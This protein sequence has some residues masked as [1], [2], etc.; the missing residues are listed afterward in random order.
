MKSVLS[1]H[2]GGKAD[3]YVDDGDKIKFGHEH[4]EVAE[5]KRFNPR[6]TKSEDEFVELMSKLNL[7]YPKQIGCVTYVSQAHKMAFTGDALLIRGCGRTDFQQG[8][9]NYHCITAMLFSVFA[10]SLNSRVFQEMLTRCIGHNYDGLLQTS[11][12]EE[13]RFNPRMTK[14]ED[15]F[16]E[17]MGKLNLEYPKQIGKS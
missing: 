9:V 17:L 11:V 4:L 7:E 1:K 12:A 8:G 10:N 16:V 15:E 13:K 3:H 5:E 2:S 6:M 14:S